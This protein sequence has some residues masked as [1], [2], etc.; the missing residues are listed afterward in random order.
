MLLTFVCNE[1]DYSQMN[2]IQLGRFI[3]RFHFLLMT[4]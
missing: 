1:I 2:R 3:F 4:Q